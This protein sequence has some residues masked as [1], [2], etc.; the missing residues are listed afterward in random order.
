M[1]THEIG[2]LVRAHAERADAL[3]ADYDNQRWNF[4]TDAAIN[5]DLL[6]AGV[7]LPDGV[8]TPAMLGLAE[9]DIEEVYYAA[10][11]QQ[12]ASNTKLDERS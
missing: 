5:D 6:A 11:A 2:H 1:L 4:A 10:L 9:G 8:V 3:G 7:P 12:A